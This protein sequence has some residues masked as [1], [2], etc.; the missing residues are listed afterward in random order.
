M[1]CDEAWAGTIR[2]T[3]HI[4][5]FRGW[6]NHDEYETSLNRLIRDLRS[7][8]NRGDTRPVN[9]SL[10]IGRWYFW[11]QMNPSAKL[12]SSPS[13]RR[14]HRLRLHR[15]LPAKRATPRLLRSPSSASSTA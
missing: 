13:L 4:G 8:N 9:F 5:D 7:E 11:K 6:K 12:F 1:N 14:S 2:R 10:C 15:L 3:R